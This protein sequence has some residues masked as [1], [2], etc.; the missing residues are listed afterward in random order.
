MLCSL[1]IVLS[2]DL[3]VTVMPLDLYSVVTSL[4]NTSQFWDVEMHGWAML[5]WFLSVFV[6]D[7]VEGSK[8]NN[9]DQKASSHKRHSLSAQ[10]EGEEPAKKTCM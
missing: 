1:D 9:P 3:S 8:E 10:Q 7:A 6:Q 2:T 4:F 5:T